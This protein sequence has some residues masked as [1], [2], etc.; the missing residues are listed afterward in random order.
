[1]KTPV[2]GARLSSNYGRRKHPILGYTRM[3]KGAD[4]AAN[5][6]TPIMAAGDGVIE[7]SARNGGYGNYVLIRHNSTYSTA[8]AHLS[9]YGRGIR[10]G[11]RVKQ[12]QIIGYIGA[13]GLAKGAHLHYEVLVNGKQVNP[14]TLKLPEGRR[15]ANQELTRYLVL[16]VN[17]E[18][19]LG[20][21]RTAGG[22]R[23]Q[24]QA[25]PSPQ[26]PVPGS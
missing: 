21:L 18:A 9:K 16:K 15:L 20:A 11:K 19:D 1:M 17:L 14:M 24:A 2:D 8:Y 23:A 12:G 13:T 6:G 7:L 4:F 26:D 3:H 25:E 10:K 5:W 22:W